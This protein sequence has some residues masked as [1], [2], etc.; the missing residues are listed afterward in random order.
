MTPT[1]LPTLPPDTGTYVLIMTVDTGQTLTIGQLGDFYFHEG[2]YAYVGSAFGAGGLR[3]RL[4]HHLKTA[5][6]PHWHIDFLRRVARVEAIWLV[7]GKQRHEHVWAT[8]VGGLPGMHIPLPRFGASDCKCPAHLFF[9]REMPHFEQ[10][11]GQHRER[12]PEDAVPQLVSLPS[13]L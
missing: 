6:K 7:T 12:F 4:G 11:V 10:F 5:A 2:C 1:T 8:M 3:A 13:E 9:S